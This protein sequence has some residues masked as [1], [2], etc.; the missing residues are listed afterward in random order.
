MEKINYYKWAS[1]TLSKPRARAFKNALQEIDNSKWS[2]EH[3]EARAAVDAIAQAHDK[4]V[5]PQVTEIQNQARA[6]VAAI[7]EQ[8]RQL[9][10]QAREINKQADDA[11]W[12]LRGAVYKTIEYTAA[13][14]LASALWHRDDDAVEPKR[15]ALMEK[16][17]AA[18]AKVG[19]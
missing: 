9:H 4:A 3:R 1:E 6:Q 5:W 19:A 13:S 7:E 8:I 2:A 16:Y 14:E 15:R 11:V 18:Q 12:A 10:E 17:A